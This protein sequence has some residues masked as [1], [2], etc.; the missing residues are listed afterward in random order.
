MVAAVPPSTNES[1]NEP[2]PIPRT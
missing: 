1:N 2:G